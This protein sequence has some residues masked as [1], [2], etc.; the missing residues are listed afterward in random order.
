MIREL[1]FRW[2]DEHGTCYDCGAP[3]AYALPARYGRSAD[4]EVREEDK[5]CSVCFAAEAYLGFGIGTYLFHD[6]VFGDGGL[7]G[8]H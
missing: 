4:S 2:S 7:G 5:L 8:D 1:K 3:A 6:E